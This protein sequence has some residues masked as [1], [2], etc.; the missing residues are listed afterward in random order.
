MLRIKKFHFL[1]LFLFDTAYIDINY[2][3]KGRI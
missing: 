2:N 3:K 1:P